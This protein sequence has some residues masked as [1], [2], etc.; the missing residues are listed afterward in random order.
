[1]L[2]IALES[3]IISLTLLALT[4]RLLLSFLKTTTRV[5]IVHAQETVSLLQKCPSLYSFKPHW[6]LPSG[7][8]QTIYSAIVNKYSK[9]QVKFTRQ[10]VK[11]PDHGIM[12][13]DWAFT[14]LN[15]DAIV[16]ICHGLAGGSNESYV[17]DLIMECKANGYPSV[18]LN[19]RGCAKTP[20]STPKLY[21]AACV[22]DI[23]TCTALIKS[24]YPNAKLIGV[25]FSL[26]S[27]V[28][29]KVAAQ[30][31]KNPFIS[32]VSVGNPYDLLG[33]TRSL[34]RRLLGRYLYIP[35]MAQALVN[36]FER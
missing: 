4:L 31:E 13:M 27:N 35:A 25:G 34:K 22:E 30:V 1:M 28:I 24:K 8:L 9:P 11:L 19:F 6:L 16:V 2:H 14:H 29:V 5:T 26:G 33:C 3:P 18:V 7:H 10:S 15:M 36:V 23:N 20:L 32:I 12:S 21:N 17:Q